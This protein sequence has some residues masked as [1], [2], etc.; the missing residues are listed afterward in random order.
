MVH[1]YNLISDE[2]LYNI[3]TSDLKDIE[4]FVS[5]IKKYISN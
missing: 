4:D 3:I 1:L 5:A 2:E